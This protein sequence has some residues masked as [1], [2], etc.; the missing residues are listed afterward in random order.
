MYTNIKIGSYMHASIIT[1]ILAQLF[2]A[3]HQ[4]LTDIY[5]Y[6]KQLQKYEDINVK[7]YINNI[8]LILRMKYFT[9]T[10]CSSLML[11]K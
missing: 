11:N 5:T 3:S 4:Q 6:V 8:N 10:S 2:S 7:P 9:H 1:H